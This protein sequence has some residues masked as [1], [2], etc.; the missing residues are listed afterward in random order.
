M[1]PKL[2][3]AGHA[4]V[5]QTAAFAL[6]AGVGLLIAACGSSNSPSASSSSAS[7]S[8]SPSS[9]KLISNVDACKLVT[10]ADAS[11]ATGATVASLSG[12]A[13]IPGVC[14]YGSSDGTTS[15]IVFAQAYPDSATAN[16]I[17]PEQIAAAIN[18]GVGVTNAKA[19]SGIGDKAVEYSTTTPG[20][21]GI[22]IFAFKSNVV[23]VIMVTPAIDPTKI[24]QLAR[25]A[26]GK[27]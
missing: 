15:V 7:H 5:R 4:L 21:N 26:V 9:L 24:E 22:V 20:T 19:V 16:A 8:P 3:H 12:G 1:G 10:S 13:Q 27:L 18:G 23:V 17:S 14:L 2:S 11:T 25:T 6:V